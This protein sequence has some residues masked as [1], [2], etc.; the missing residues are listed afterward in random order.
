[1]QQKSEVSYDALRQALAAPTVIVKY[2]FFGFVN[3]AA[4]AIVVSVVDKF[5]QLDN[6]VVWAG[7][8]VY[9][10]LSTLRRRR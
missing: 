9:L 10:T 8:C 6:P 3:L 1:M 5:D 2:P 4:I 7:I